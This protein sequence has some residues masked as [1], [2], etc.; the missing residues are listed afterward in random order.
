MFITTSFLTLSIPFAKNLPWPLAIAFFLFFG[1]IDG[2]SSPPLFAFLFLDFALTRY[3]SL[4]TQVYSGVVPSGRCLMELGTLSPSESLCEFSTAPFNIETRRSLYLFSVPS[5]SRST[6]GL[7]TL[8]TSSTT[9][10]TPSYPTSSLD[11]RR[12]PTNKRT[13]STSSRNQS[14]KGR[15]PREFESSSMDTTGIELW[16]ETTTRLLLSPTR[17]SGSQSLRVSSNSLGSRRWPSS[18]RLRMEEEFL[19]PS[20]RS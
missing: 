2:K 20:T 16:E 3:L 13:R 15:L 11:R 1:F 4:F 19:T 5:C 18:T 7:D 17:R 14:R 8:S 10:T 6:P 9:R 12:S